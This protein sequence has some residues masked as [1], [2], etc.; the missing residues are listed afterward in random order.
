MSLS[1]ERL[2]E[3]EKE[4]MGS[5]G[6]SPDVLDEL[7]TDDWRKSCQ[8]VLEELASELLKDD[9]NDTAED[10]NDDAG[11]LEP[12]DD[13]I[14]DGDGSGKA[15]ADDAG[16]LEPSD[17]GIVDGD[18]SGKADADNAGALEPNDDRTGNDN[19]GALESNDDGTGNDN[20]GALEPNDDR[21]GNDDVWA[22]AMVCLLSISFLLVRVLMV[23]NTIA[24]TM[25]REMPAVNRCCIDVFWK[26]IAERILGYFYPN[27]N[28]RLFLCG[29]LFPH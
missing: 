28:P 29:H 11:A 6:V 10:G 24:M 8:N 15:D 4:L 17:D 27:D 5:S 9:G 14:V 23:M 22:R 1:F 25:P 20:A 26:K 19:A 16:A 7:C 21:T 12:S 3:D 18:G 2:A 13:G